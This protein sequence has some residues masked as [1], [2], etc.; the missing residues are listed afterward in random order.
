MA[1]ESGKRCPLKK[2]RPSGRNPGEGNPWR[3]MR[4]TFGEDL[5]ALTKRTS[6]GAVLK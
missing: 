4:R 6:K 3:E 5:R 1:R 2:K